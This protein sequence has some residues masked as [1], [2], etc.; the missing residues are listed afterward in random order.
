M[1][2]VF[3][4]PSSAAGSALPDRSAV[5]DDAR[6]WCFASAGESRI[7]AFVSR[8][9]QTWPHGQQTLP[10]VRRGSSLVGRSRVGS[11][12]TGTLN[13]RTYYESAPQIFILDSSSHVSLPGLLACLRDQ[14]AGR[15]HLIRNDQPVLARRSA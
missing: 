3:P 2:G 5:R 12:S 15:S 6:N 14:G 10:A 9:R 11:I 13:C 4:S 1:T 8:W 7:A